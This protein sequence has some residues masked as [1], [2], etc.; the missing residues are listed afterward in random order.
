MRSATQHPASRHR[1]HLR[2]QPSLLQPLKI[3]RTQRRRRQ[4]TTAK[5]VRERLASRDR[6]R[7]FCKKDTS[8]VVHAAVE[9]H[10]AEC[11]LRVAWVGHVC[12]SDGAVFDEFV[13]DLSAKERSVS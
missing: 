2:L 7:S 13:L 4:H 10:A 9:T 5:L 6:D 11:A 1:P 3:R 12:V 8:E